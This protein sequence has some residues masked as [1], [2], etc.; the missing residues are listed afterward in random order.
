MWNLSILGKKKLH[1]KR[2]L[3]EIFLSECLKRLFPI[4][5]HPLGKYFLRATV[6]G[7]V[8]GTGDPAVTRWIENRA[9]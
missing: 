1:L 3:P 8:L 6:P 2:E 5:F 7:S 9:L 4:D